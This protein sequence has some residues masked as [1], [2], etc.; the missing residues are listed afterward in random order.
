MSRLGTVSAALSYM[1]KN[2]VT[3]LRWAAQCAQSQAWRE[4]AVLADET[5]WNKRMAPYRI[6]F[7]EFLSKF[8][9][10]PTRPIR[11][12]DSTF[13]IESVNGFELYVL[14][15]LCR[16]LDASRVMEIGTFKGRTTYNLAANIA[17]GGRIYTLN[18]LDAAHEGAF[19][20][21]EAFRGTALESRIDAMT[22][23]SLHFDFRP[24]HGSIDLMFVDGNHSLPYV[25]QDSKSALQCVR[26]GGLIAWH[27]VSFDHADVTQ[28]VLES[29]ERHGVTPWLIEGTQIIVAIRP[30]EVSFPAGEVSARS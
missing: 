23:N 20:P 28:A 6:R 2:P 7:E 17:E 9:L 22:G 14:C 27:D 26:P 25:L 21:G 19:V 15:T 4:A 16:S 29:C 18:Y 24:W 13:Q 8:G 10:E 5:E 1:L 30:D 3:V 12:M 11:M